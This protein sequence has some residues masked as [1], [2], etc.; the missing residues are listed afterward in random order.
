MAE[1]V[2]VNDALVCARGFDGVYVKI[3][4]VLLLTD[5]TLIATVLSGFGI[6][7]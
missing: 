6:D 2:R 7:L 1:F 5:I 3:T 4:L